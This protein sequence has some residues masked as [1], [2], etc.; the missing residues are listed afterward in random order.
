MIGIAAALPLLAALSS[1]GR[2]VSIFDNPADLIAFHCKGTLT[3]QFPGEEQTKIDHEE[4]IVADTAKRRVFKVSPLMTAP[5]DLCG[6][7]HC[8]VVIS[9]EVITVNTSDTADQKMGSLGQVRSITDTQLNLNRVTGTL[10]TR[11]GDTARLRD[12]SEGH[13]TQQLV[14]QCQPEP[15]ARANLSPPKN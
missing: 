5:I 6:S 2:P 9:R 11:S 1:C 15:P 13:S 10:T 4:H 7:D 12:Q 14:E 3:S 8:A